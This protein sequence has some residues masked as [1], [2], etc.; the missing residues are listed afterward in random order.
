MSGPVH[1]LPR[2][3]S[4]FGAE[5]TKRTNYQINLVYFFSFHDYTSLV[6]TLYHK[7]DAF[8]MHIVSFVHLP[9]E[10][11]KITSPNHNVIMSSREKGEQNRN[12]AL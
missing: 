9:S 8:C 6:K 12:K 7:H 1:S 3:S 2:T 10:Y 5:G 11:E 4:W